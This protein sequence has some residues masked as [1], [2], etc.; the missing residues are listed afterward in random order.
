[1]RKGIS[2]TVTAGDRVRLDA[3]IGDRN[4][5][6]KHVWRARIVLLTVDGNGTNTITRAVGKDKTSV[7]RWQERFMHEGIAGFDPRQDP[8]LASWTYRPE[9]DVNA[10]FDEARPRIFGA[11][12]DAVIS[13]LRHKDNNLP[14]SPA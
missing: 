12:L 14:E 3:I 13:A 11:L 6:Q 8:P 7:W 9:A 1:M 4:S 2:I 5:P 10:E